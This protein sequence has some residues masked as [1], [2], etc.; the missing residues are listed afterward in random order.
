MA[1][2][3][4]LLI[5]SDSEDKWYFDKNFLEE[6]IK[7]GK[8]KLNSEKLSR[9][10]RQFLK[11]DIETFERFI[12]GNFEFE[13]YN[14][15][16]PK[17]KD[18][19][20]DYILKRMIKQYKILGEETIRWVISL[21]EERIF[22]SIKY[23]IRSTE[24]SL[25]E[26]VELTIKNYEKNNPKFLIPAKK[27][28]L[29]N[30]VKQIQTVEFY[31]SWCHH[32]SITGLS[33]LIINSLEEPCILN[34]EV[35]HAIEV[36][37]KYPTNSLYYELGPI[38]YEMLFNEELYKSRGYLELRDFDF[39]LDEVEYLLSVI[40][41]YFEIMLL[42]KEKNF[43]IPTNEFFETFC[44]IN[45]IKPG[46]V[47]DYLKEEIAND[48]IVRDMRYLFSFLKAIEL[49]E[50]KINNPQAELLEPYI[51]SKKFNFEIPQDSFR[52]YD[53]YIEEMNQKVKK[54]TKY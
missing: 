51:K 47:E 17:N 53:R 38:Y 28:I 29:D 30:S 4:P 15:S 46:M 7:Q 22:E 44:K 49:R 3:I 35:E 50:A 27:I 52:I 11:S 20:K 12:K 9:R 14:L 1:K 6:A 54:K 34:H 40:S 31:P 39:R 8:E 37:F 24:L 16:F 43:D 5:N 23:S 10:K 19:F 26:K 45:S 2:D 41:S 13:P 48:N 21:H 33:Y 32:D 18:K 42:F 36:A 25:E